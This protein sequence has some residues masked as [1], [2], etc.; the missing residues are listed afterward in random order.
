MKMNFGLMDTIKGCMTGTKREK[1]MKMPEHQINTKIMIIGFI[2]G[3]GF[4]L[5]KYLRRLPIKKI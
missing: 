1:K 2:F 4:I 3:M 5:M